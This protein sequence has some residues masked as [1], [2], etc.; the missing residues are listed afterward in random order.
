MHNLGSFFP[1]SLTAS[2]FGYSPAGNLL[3][4]AAIIWSIVWKGF[5]LWRAAKNE[6]R[7]WFVVL[8]VINTLGILEILYLF[9]FSK[10]KTASVAAAPTEERKDV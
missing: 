2:G 1:D 3:L 9:V 8:L 10:K 7:I 5:A 4:M 6:S